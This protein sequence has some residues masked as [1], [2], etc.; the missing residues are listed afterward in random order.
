MRSARVRQ[1]CCRIDRNHQHASVATE[2]RMKSLLL[3]LAGVL[4]GANVVYFMVARDCRAPITD[5]TT[6][7]TVPAPATHSPVASQPSAPAAGNVSPSTAPPTA[8]DA[9]PVVSAAALMQ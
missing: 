5:K 7:A 8:T 4:V 6:P 1:P 2:V 9:A 3:F